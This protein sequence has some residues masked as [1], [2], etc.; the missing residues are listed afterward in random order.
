M[1]AA[2]E[3]NALLEKDPAGALAQA[4]QLEAE[5]VRR[6][7]TFDGAAMRSFLRPHFLTRAAWERLR[8]DGRRLLEL[9]ARVA[10]LLDLAASEQP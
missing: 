4:Q 3:Y 6:G 7:V 1:D 5:F 2:A 9:A 8:D 10:R